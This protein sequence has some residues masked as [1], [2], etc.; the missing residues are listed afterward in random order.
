M[1][2]IVLMFP[3]LALVTLLCV[4]PAMA[5]D[6]YGFASYWDKK[7]ADGSWGAGLGVS[8]PLFTEVL[9][10]DGRMYYFENS[11]I[12][13][14][15]DLTLTPFDLGLQVH[16]LPGA[17]LDPYLL[18]GVS[19]IHA[20]ADRF[21]ADSSF[22]GYLGAGLETE[23]GVPLFTLFGEALYRFSSI[24]TDLGHDIDVNG[25]TVNLGLKFHF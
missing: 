20:D 22:G 24:D 23:L 11:D 18:G 4:P 14:G 12:G 19:Y 13:P 21:D 3:T 7:D 15:E 10:L 16:P 25:F 17:S 2:K 6:L 8:L 9:R 1:K 5:I